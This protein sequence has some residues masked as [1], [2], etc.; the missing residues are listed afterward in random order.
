MDQIKFYAKAEVAKNK[1]ANK[2][3]EKA[4]ISM[5]STHLAILIASLAPLDKP[6]SNGVRLSKSA[7]EKFLKTIHQAQ[8]NFS[9]NGAWFV[10]GAVID[11]WID[12]DTKE[13]K[14]AFTFYKELYPKEYVKLLEAQSDGTLGIS[15]ELLADTNSTEKLN[16][17]TIL[18][19]NFEYTGIG[20]LGVIDKKTPAYEKGRIHEFASELKERV[21]NCEYKELIFAEEILNNCDKILEENQESNID[22]SNITYTTSSSGHTV[23]FVNSSTEDEFD[24]DNYILSE[25]EIEDFVSEWKN[26]TKKNKKTN[27]K[28]KDLGGNK[29]MTEEQKALVA[30]IRSELGNFIPADIKDEELLDESKVSIYRQAKLDA[31][32]VKSDEKATAIA[33]S[34]SLSQEVLSR[35]TTYKD[36]GST[37]TMTKRD[38]IYKFIDSDGATKTD[39]VSQE[40]VA[41]TMFSAEE[42]KTKEDKIANLE[43]EIIKLKS[44]IEIK[45]KEV[46]D[47]KA[48]ELTKLEAEKK[49]KI[50]E[51]K[52]TLKDNKYVADFKDEDFLDESKIAN[53]KLL[54]ERDD[55]KAEVEALK[56]SKEVKV[57]EIKAEEK[58][59]KKII[60]NLDNP[61]DLS[62]TKIIRKMK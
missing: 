6:N 20:L 21:N 28:R 30:Q 18:I 38:C 24:E 35:I 50:E 13:T 36:D 54:Q 55:L 27:K 41:I 60:S 16:D 9:H 43:S 39:T 47:F 62:V 44:E 58:P 4:G 48:K 23:T 5:P 2:I 19:N 33:E 57:E 17:G 56:G 34:K 53:A 22:A 14:V 40:E 42:I 26:L 15:F 8:V 59:K 11:E 52:A 25:K 1:L 61:E 32:K 10:N 51:V 3:A 29:T 31:E 46:E 37:E 7:S 12:Y 45:S 49:A